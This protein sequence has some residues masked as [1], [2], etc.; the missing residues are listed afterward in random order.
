MN[1]LH[2]IG[3]WVD[4]I[5]RELYALKG[6]SYLLETTAITLQGVPRERL[7]YVSAL[8]SQLVDDLETKLIVLDEQVQK[9]QGGEVAA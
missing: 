7:P 4:S 1:H 8:C 9:L 6:F 3:D 5:D 2:L